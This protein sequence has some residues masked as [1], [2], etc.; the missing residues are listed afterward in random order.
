MKVNESSR[1]GGE[2]NKK[3]TWLVTNHNGLSFIFDALSTPTG[4]VQN[5]LHFL[6]LERLASPS[7]L[8]A[9]GKTGK[10][11]IPPFERILIT[12][13]VTTSREKCLKNIF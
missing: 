13:N 10:D 11:N 2:N 1:T 7:A 12:L 3:L 6:L 9:E 8:I 5:D 4:P